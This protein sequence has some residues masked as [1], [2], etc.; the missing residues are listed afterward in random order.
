MSKPVAIKNYSGKFPKATAAFAADAEAMSND[1]YFVASHS[2]AKNSWGLPL[3]LMAACLIPMGG[4]GFFLL[5][6][7]L[8]CPPGGTITVVYKK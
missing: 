7:M 3:C 4:L 5:A 6:Y 8:I 2:Y 1:G